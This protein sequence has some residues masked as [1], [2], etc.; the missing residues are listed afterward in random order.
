MGKVSSSWLPSLSSLSSDDVSRKFFIWTKRLSNPR[1]TIV[2]ESPLS[3]RHFGHFL[4]K[5]FVP[6][7]HWLTQAWQ[8]ITLLHSTQP[9]RGFFA[10][11]LLQ[12]IQ[13]NESSSSDKNEALNWC[14]NDRSWN[15]RISFFTSFNSFI[16]F[17]TL[18]SKL[19]SSSSIELLL[20]F[21]SVGMVSSV[22]SS[23]STSLCC[24]TAAASTAN[25]FRDPTFQNVIPTKTK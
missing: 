7:Y 1:K 6:E 2:F 13:V 23:I 20:L 4:C 5:P 9:I 25:N 11:I 22:S 8:P 3:H 19:F 18:A 12:I 24:S 14:L 16:I 17:V 21:L 15:L 10:G